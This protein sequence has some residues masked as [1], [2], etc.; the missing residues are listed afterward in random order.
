MIEEF[1]LDLL[2]SFALPDLNC[3]RVD[4]YPRVTFP[5]FMTSANRELMPSAFFLL[6]FAGAIVAV[7]RLYVDL[8]CGVRLSL[9][10]FDG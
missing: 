2:T 10:R 8:E 1:I 3:L 5:D 4:L 9:R 7:S 6:F